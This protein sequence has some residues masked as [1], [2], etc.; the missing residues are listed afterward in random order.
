M[1]FGPW[2]GEF[3]YELLY[4]L[5]R[6][7]FLALREPRPHLVYGYRGRQ[8]LYKGV[9]DAYLEMRPELEGLLE[10]PYGPFCRMGDEELF[11]RYV[12]DDVERVADMFGDL[13]DPRRELVV[14]PDEA[15]PEKATFELLHPT[16]EATRYKETLLRA[17]GINRYWTIFP[18]SKTVHSDDNQEVFHSI[19]PEESWIELV[20]ALYARW[21]VPL[22]VV[23]VKGKKGYGGVFLADYESEACHSFVDE[24]SEVE[25][26]RGLDLQI[27][28]HRGADLSFGI[29]GGAGI[30]AMLCG[31]P[32]LLVVDDQHFERFE[33]WQK[34]F[35]LET[36]HFVRVP[37]ERIWAYTVSE[38]QRVVDAFGEGL[39]PIDPVKINVGCGTERLDGYI[40]VDPFVE[41]ADHDWD[42][43]HLEVG[44][45]SVDEICAY[46]VIE[47]LNRDE[48]YTAIAHWFQKLRPGGRV[49]VECPDLRQVC[50]DYLE[51]REEG[52]TGIFGNQT[53]A[54][55]VHGWG[56]TLE[57]LSQVFESVGLAVTHKGPGQDG[58]AID[59][60]CI[61]VEGVKPC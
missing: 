20:E 9:C 25:D 5:P 45:S 47:H 28:L 4:W 33:T 1:I 32:S 56:Y 11:K 36:S 43:C 57:S 59:W 26:G 13:Y 51:G 46:H 22:V 60:P 16:V 30:L 24:C 17:R 15:S 40:N 18:R 52:I 23:G 35:G 37:D 10:E 42:A 44:D 39:E 58:H 34:W 31:G 29:R 2:V 21:G 12:K 14:T 55:Q 7:R 8:V 48:G 53:H 6:L 27:A 38:F 54:G 3:S 61:R 49:V 19:W 50:I 41:G